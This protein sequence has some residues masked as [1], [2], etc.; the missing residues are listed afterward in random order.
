[1][2][3]DNE[4]LHLIEGKNIKIDKD[5]YAY[6][7][8]NHANQYIHRLVLGN[9]KGLEIDHI[10]HDIL[11]NRKENLR[12][13]TKSQNAANRNRKNTGEN[14]SKYKGVY[15][16]NKS[17]KGNVYTYYGAKV[18]K[19]GKEYQKSFKNEIDAAKWYDKTALEVHGE[20]AKLNFP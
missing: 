11:D 18:K 5:G 12:I 10:N 19:N 15:K 2:L 9:P 20:Y 14:Q 16:F 1:M 4:D 8:R 7:K 13:V 17:Y 6:F 3:I